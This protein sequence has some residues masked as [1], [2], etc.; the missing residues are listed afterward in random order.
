MKTARQSDRN[1]WINFGK[2]AAAAGYSLDWLLAPIKPEQ[3]GTIELLRQGH[4]AET[5]RIA[6]FEKRKAR[7]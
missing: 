6:R 7:P 3:T 4:E 2:R 1:Y 5:K